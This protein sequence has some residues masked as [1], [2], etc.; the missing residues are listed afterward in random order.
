[1]LFYSEKLKKFFDSP[2]ECTSAEEAQ[3]KKDI[4][5]KNQLEV[6]KAKVAEAETNYKNACKEHTKAEERAEELSKRYMDEL[7][8]ILI[9]SEEKV[10]DTYDVLLKAKQDLKNYQEKVKKNSYTPPEFKWIND[11]TDFFR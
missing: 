3:E 2:D 11:I 6:L 7:D 4:E 10:G 9:P 1:M 5:N 8:K